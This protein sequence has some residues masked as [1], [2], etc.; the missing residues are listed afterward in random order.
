M[1]FE[2][3]SFIE[4]TFSS[5]SHNK[6]CILYSTDLKLIKRLVV[7]HRAYCVTPIRFYLI[8]TCLLE[9]GYYYM[10]QNFGPVPDDGKNVIVDE[11]NLTVR[12][13]KYPA[14]ADLVFE[15]STLFE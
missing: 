12:H 14:D 4:S 3:D 9:N 8:D 15:R 11:G 5:L 1:F 13:E 2:S 7:I 10:G 6:D